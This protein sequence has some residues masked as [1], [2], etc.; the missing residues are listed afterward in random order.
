MDIEN[1]PKINLVCLSKNFSKENSPHH[2]N[3]TAVQ[4]KVVH[5]LI[6][7]FLSEDTDKS[8]EWSDMVS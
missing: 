2:S 6:S 5:I 4:C 7:G 1:L 8:E 3:K